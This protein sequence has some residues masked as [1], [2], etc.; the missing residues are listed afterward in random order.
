MERMKALKT[1]MWFAVGFMVVVG[2][3]FL[4]SRLLGG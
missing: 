3:F 2:G 4:I 1:L